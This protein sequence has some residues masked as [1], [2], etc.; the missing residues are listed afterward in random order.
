MWFGNRVAN[1]VSAWWKKQN[2][3]WKKRRPWI[4]AAVIAVVVIWAWTSNG[5]KAHAKS[6]TM[7][8]GYASHG[9]GLLVQAQSKPG[10]PQPLVVVLHDDSSAVSSQD[11]NTADKVRSGSGLENLGNKRG[12]RFAVG[13]GEAVASTWRVGDSGDEQYVRDIVNYIAQ[14]RSKIDLHR[15]YLWGIGEGGRMAIDVACS[16]NAVGQPHMF[17]AVAVL[18]E[19]PQ[20]ASCPS[21]MGFQQWNTLKWTSGVSKQMWEFSRGFHT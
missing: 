1:P 21:G 7:P 16:A 13:Y 11:F 12:D 8:G 17:A 3:T 15:V 5:D 20:P 19:N 2:D 10:K 4:I 18:G 14:H 9:R 6:A